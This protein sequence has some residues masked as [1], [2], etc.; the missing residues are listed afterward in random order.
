ML[1]TSQRRRGGKI[2]AGCPDKDQKIKK[3]PNVKRV[4]LRQ[5]AAGLQVGGS[6]T[7]MKPSRTASFL[8]RGRAGCRGVNA[9]LNVAA[10]DIFL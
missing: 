3:N 4:G 8:L 5:M 2:D 7:V 6:R 10:A 9:P 1:R